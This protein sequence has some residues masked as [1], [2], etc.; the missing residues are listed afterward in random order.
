MYDYQRI[1]KTKSFGGGRVVFT[2]T[3]IGVTSGRYTVA[4]DRVPDVVNGIIPAGTPIFVNDETRVADIHYAFKTIA[5]GT[6]TKSRVEKGFEGSRAKVGMV[7]MIAP[8]TIDG[9]GTAVAITAVDRKDG[10][11]ELT[12][13]PLTGA[14]VA[15]AILVEASAVGATSTIKVKPNGY[16]FYDFAKDP[17]AIK[18]WID[19]LFS[20]TDGVLLENRVPPIAPAV[21]TYLADPNGGN[22]YVR[23]SKSQE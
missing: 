5:G 15:G 1:A 17:N 10:Y 16:S 18:M 19:A 7:L 6:T 13:A 9:T 4:I 14:E 2:G 11:D 23:Y 20:H 3:R 21:K 22:S 8:A 12:H